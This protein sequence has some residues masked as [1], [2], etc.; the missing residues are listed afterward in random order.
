M[1]KDK[2][3][4]YDSLY[5]TCPHYG[6]RRGNRIEVLIEEREFRTILAHCNHCSMPFYFDHYFPVTRENQ[7]PD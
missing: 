6:C 4:R 5:V 7:Y 3:N 1:S 2:K